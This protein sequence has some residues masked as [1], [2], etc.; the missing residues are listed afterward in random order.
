MKEMLVDVI[1]RLKHGEYKNEEHVRLSMV[2]RVLEH[3]GWNIW[4]PREVFT[5]F[6]AVRKEDASRVDVALLMPPELL[7]P[8]VFIEVKAVGKLLPTLDSAELQ[9]RDY[10]RANRADISLLTD[11]QHWRFYVDEQAGEFG[12]QYRL[13]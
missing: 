9:L 12:D 11:G 5:E 13:W 3:L 7:R 4:N 8:A 10:N 6:Q 2:C 1:S